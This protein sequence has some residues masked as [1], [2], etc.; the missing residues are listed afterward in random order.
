[1]ETTTAL[2][3]KSERHIRSFNMKH[4]RETVAFFLEAVP[5]GVDDLA[6]P[7]DF[8]EFID[9]LIDHTFS[10]DRGVDFDGGWHEAIVEPCVFNFVES[11]MPSTHS[12]WRM[13]EYVDGKS[14]WTVE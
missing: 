10:T 12:A 5:F 11:W 6:A 4:L 8:D 9:E 14:R 1:M 7:Y 3:I 13:S 2:P